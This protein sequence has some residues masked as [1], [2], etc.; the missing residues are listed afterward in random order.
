MVLDLEHPWVKHP[1]LDQ[2]RAFLINQVA[3][4]SGACDQDCSVLTQVFQAFCQQGFLKAQLPKSLKGLGLNATEYGWF[5]ILLVQYSGA[6]TLLQGQ[7][8]MSVDRL[9][10]NPTQRALALISRIV[11]EGLGLGIY[12]SNTY[13][14]RHIHTT[15]EKDSVILNA[16]LPW[17]TG[18][19]Y[20]SHFLFS[21]SPDDTV[22]HYVLF[23]LTSCAHKEGSIEIS[24]PLPLAV[25]SATQTVQVTIRNWCITPEDILFSHHPKAFPWKPPVSLY[26]FVGVARKALSMVLDSEHGKNHVVEQRFQL[27]KDRLVQ[28]TQELFDQEQPVNAP[29]DFRAK[30]Y[31][32]MTQCL[33]LAQL[34]V[35]GKMLLP[36]HPLLRLL[37]EAHQYT[38]SGITEKQIEGYVRHDLN[39][40]G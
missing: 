7:H 33:Q 20:F 5:R 23:P 11:D 17:V 9:L 38:L 26:S 37:L 22:V 34:M 3:P 18:Y 4:L 30:G 24:S 13:R 39:S 29:L 25:M 15:L 27:L 19:G 12:T 31:A 16:Q 10:L 40:F 14:A 35:G 6:L 32:L 8:Q 2:L 21:F 36:H 28:Y 1:V